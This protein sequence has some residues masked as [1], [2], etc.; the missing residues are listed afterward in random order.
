MRRPRVWGIFEHLLEL[1]ALFGGVVALQMPQTRLFQQVFK[2]AG[3]L[4][5]VSFAGR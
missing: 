5:R 4:F 3:G 1:V 2:A